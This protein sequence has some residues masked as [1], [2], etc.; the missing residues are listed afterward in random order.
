MDVELTLKWLGQLF[1][2]LMLSLQK[3]IMV[4]APWRMGMYG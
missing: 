4:S 3:I 2:V 1:Q